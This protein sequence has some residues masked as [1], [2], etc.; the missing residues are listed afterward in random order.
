MRIT[1]VIWAHP[2]QMQL[3]IHFFNNIYHCLLFTYK[4]CES[5]L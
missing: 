2:K 1:V 3:K 4:V 5:M